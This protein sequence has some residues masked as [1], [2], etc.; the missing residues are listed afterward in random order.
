MGR[1]GKAT[2][3]EHTNISN[4]CSIIVVLCRIILSVSNLLHEIEF[5]TRFR[6]V[7]YM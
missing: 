6:F 5:K 3:L 7:Y 4:E 1:Q 2:R